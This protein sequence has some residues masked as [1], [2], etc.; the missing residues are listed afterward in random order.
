MTLSRILKL[1]ETELPYPFFQTLDKDSLLK[2][3]STSDIKIVE[4]AFS[5]FKK[6]H[7]FLKSDKVFTHPRI[8]AISIRLA[9]KVRGKPLRELSAIIDKEIEKIRIAEKIE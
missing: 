7:S 1:N 3:K 9:Y 4:I 6:I 5:I 2:N 8:Q